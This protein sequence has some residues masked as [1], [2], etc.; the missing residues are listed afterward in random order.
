MDNNTN[1][2]LIQVPD[3]LAELQAKQH[4]KYLAALTNLVTSKTPRDVVFERPIRGGAKV[5]Y[6][7]GWWFIQQLN[8]LFGYLWDFEIDEQSVGQQQVWVRGKLTVK[9]PNGIT[10]TK[11]AFGGADI[12]KYSERNQ[13]KAGQIIDIADDLKAASTDA[14]KKAATLLGIAS[15]IY[16]QR[17]VIEQ[18]G[19][20]RKHLDALYKLGAAKDMTKEQVDDLCVAEHGGRPEELEMAYVLGLMQKLRTRP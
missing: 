14:M 20:G 1:T 11:T 15:D 7:P 4:E 17:E 5:D 16:G 9:L 2:S 12:K 3:E 18:T 13:E 19:P 8:A 10:V 6:V